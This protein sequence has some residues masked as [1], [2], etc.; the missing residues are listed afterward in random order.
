MGKLSEILSVFNGEDI[1]DQEETTSKKESK[2]AGAKSQKK[3]PVASEE[4][5]L[6]A[7]IYAAENSSLSGDVLAVIKGGQVTPQ[8]LNLLEVLMDNE[9]LRKR[10]ISQ[11]DVQP[12]ADSYRLEYRF[13]KADGEK[14]T[15][16]ATGFLSSGKT[17]KDLEG[18]GVTLVVERVDKKT[19]KKTPGS[20][21]DYELITKKL[22]SGETANKAE[23][24]EPDKDEKE[25]KDSK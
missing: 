22:E 10:V 23:K 24:P 7:A 18:L 12:A 20:N 19:G 6:N 2:A 1:D 17:V 8:L 25:S 4:A 15:K 21:R 16:L 13:V 5:K 14:V 11:A 9:Q 3:E